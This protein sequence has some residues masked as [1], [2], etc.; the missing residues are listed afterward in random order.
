MSRVS[1]DA[2]GTTMSIREN[3][4]PSVVCGEHIFRPELECIAALVYYMGVSVG[5]TDLVTK[6]VQCDF[7]LDAIEKVKDLSV[8]EYNEFV[9]YIASRLLNPDEQSFV[10]KEL[11]ED[12]Q[13]NCTC[14]S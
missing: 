9:S 8:E 4:S 3:D 2:I 6:M 11:L 14:C 13:E 12:F 5:K 7:H 1:L 10:G